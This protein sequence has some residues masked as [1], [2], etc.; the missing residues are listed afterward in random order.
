LS[1]AYL[2]GIY[3]EVYR[4]VSNSGVVFPKIIEAQVLPKNFLVVQTKIEDLGLN[5][6]AAI[7]SVLSTYPHG[8]TEA[9]LRAALKVALTDQVDTLILEHA[10]EWF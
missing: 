4:S 6:T 8:A 2:E 5:P 7:Q 10:E 3:T 9:T 1:Q